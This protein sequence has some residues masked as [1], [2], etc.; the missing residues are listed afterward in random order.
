MIL[1]MNFMK[2]FKKLLLRKKNL[3]LAIISCGLSTILGA[4]VQ[5][6]PSCVNPKPWGE[7]GLTRVGVW[8]G[9]THFEG[10]N[11]LK[12]RQLFSDICGLPFPA[13]QIERVIL[14][15]YSA[16]GH[17][18]AKLLINGQQIDDTQTIPVQQLPEGPG[19]VNPIPFKTRNLNPAQSA[20]SWQVQLVG[21]ITV[22][23]VFFIY[24]LPTL[25]LGSRSIGAVPADYTF[26]VPQAGA[27]NT[28]QI[29]A[30]QKDLFIEKISIEIEIEGVGNQ[31][32]ELPDSL[33]L[34]ELLMGQ[35]K[36][37]GL[38]GVSENLKNI[39]VRASTLDPN[40]APAALELTL[41]NQ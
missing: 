38:I 40:Q 7:S 2:K 41:K 15:A 14:Y 12:L 6:G 20:G 28:L 29:K 18:K 27:F 39:F 1:M 24:R 21:N 37:T 9:V 11:T 13:A 3:S 5:A 19:D 35:S 32:L 17:G 22:K 8:L 26:P 16:E 25:N 36:S 10:E 33:M 4:Q 30:L 34:N 23:K 31:I